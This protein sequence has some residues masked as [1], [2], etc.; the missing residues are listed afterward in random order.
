MTFD[1]QVDKILLVLVL[2][3]VLVSHVVK[4]LNKDSLWGEESI[5]IL[6]N[7]ECTF[8]SYSGR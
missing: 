6:A 3:L 2:V 4:H 8:C 7:H 5:L 1:L